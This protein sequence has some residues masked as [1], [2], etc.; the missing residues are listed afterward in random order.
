MA[1]AAVQEYRGPP[2]TRRGRK[3]R[4]VLTTADGTVPSSRSH[5][6]TYK[7]ESFR[8]FAFATGKRHLE[9]NRLGQVPLAGIIDEFK[10]ANP[11][12]VVPTSLHSCL[13]WDNF[14]RA[15]TNND[16]SV[17]VLKRHTDPTRNTKTMHDKLS[18]RP[19]L[20]PVVDWCM[21]WIRGAREKH[22]TPSLSA[23]LAAW[24]REGQ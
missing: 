20:A 21:A 18:L 11:S 1:I 12:A 14:I 2:K 5:S 7:H 17:L 10:A 3:P 6:S 9:E 15:V 16:I 8:H 24:A 4:I 13:Q 22:V 19:D 23:M